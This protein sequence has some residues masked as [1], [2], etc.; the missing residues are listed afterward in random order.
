MTPG[1]YMGIPRELIDWFPTIDEDL[2]IACGECLDTCPN[3]VYVLDENA[4]VMRVA[5]PGNC[6]VLC[7]KCATFCPQEAVSFPDKNAFLR[8]LR[9]LLR[10]NRE[11]P[12]G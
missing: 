10:E 2:C 11:K 12:A 5:N 6:V 3:G 7:D 9:R 8:E 4:G 1:A